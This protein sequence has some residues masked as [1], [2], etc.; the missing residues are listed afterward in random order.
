MESVSKSMD[1]QLNQLLEEAEE[2]L[3]ELE[4]DSLGCV[5]RRYLDVQD[6]VFQ[7]VMV[8][9]S[10]RPQPAY[11]WTVSGCTLKQIQTVR[12][13]SGGTNKHTHFRTSLAHPPSRAYFPD[14]S[15]IPH[16]F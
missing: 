3:Q 16:T 13:V 8:V 7:P 5:R 11:E 12:A 6:A 15:A 4:E 9:L 14:T 1:Q 2:E 10:R